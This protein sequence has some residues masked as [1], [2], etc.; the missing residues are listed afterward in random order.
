MPTDSCQTGPETKRLRLRRPGRLDVAP[1]GDSR[2]AVEP[3]KSRKGLTCGRSKQVTVEVKR[4]RASDR[5]SQSMFPSFKSDKEFA[6]ESDLRNYLVKNLEIV[7]PSLQVYE[8][9]GVTGIEF[10]V[11]GRFIDILAVDEHGAFVV[12]ELKVS[13]GYDRVVGQVLRYM[14]WVSDNLESSLP[15]R[16]IIVAQKVSDDLKLAASRIP[17]I[18]LVEYQITFSLLR[19]S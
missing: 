18:S 13:R 11:G 10:P 17:E 4:K 15:V 5:A 8:Q 2:G 9:N 16:G 12:I 6:F 3:N 1:L 19:L 14:A 7:E